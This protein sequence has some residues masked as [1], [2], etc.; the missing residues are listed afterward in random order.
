MNKKLT[1]ALDQLAVESFDTG[2]ASLSRGTVRGRD[3]TL[4]VTCKPALCDTEG[5]TC[6]CT[7]GICPT[8][9]GHTCQPPSCYYSCPGTC[10]DTC[11]C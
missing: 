9:D 6:G 11:F 5:D 4:E 8:V 10:G 1:L 2:A 7:A 3:F